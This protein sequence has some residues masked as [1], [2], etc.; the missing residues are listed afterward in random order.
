M[1]LNKTIFLLAFCLLSCCSKHEDSLENND[2]QKYV[3][4]EDIV[5]ASPEGFDLTLDIY[6]PSSNK[7]SYPVL[8]IFHGGG[9]LVNDNSI[10]DQ[11][12]QYLATNSEYVICNVNYRLLSDKD[13]TITLNEIVEDAFGALIWIKH[14]ISRYKGDNSKIAVT[15]DSAGAHLSAMIVNSGVKLSSQGRFENSLSFTPTYLPKGKTAEQ[16]GLDNDLTVQAAILSYGTF[17]IY[18]S[19]LEGFETFK[20]PFWLISKSKARGVFGNQYNATKNPQMY[21]A[22]SPIYNIPK[23]EYMTLP[24]QFILV[25]SKDKLTTPASVKDYLY[26]L[27]SF[28]HEAQYWEYKDRNHAFLDSGSNFFLDS[29]FEEDAPEAIEMM[30]NFLDGVFAKEKI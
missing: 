27:K 19:A 24:P 5:W 11:M 2:P 14:N 8:V 30:I 26:K 4:E 9:W 3:L 23:Q 10:M 15:G 6:T 20:N 18:N 17:D 21:K 16:T 25:G 12:S 1:M 7:K 22:L 28:G 29:S 13:N